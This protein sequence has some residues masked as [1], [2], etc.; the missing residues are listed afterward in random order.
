MP[1]TCGY[2]HLCHWEYVSDIPATPGSEIPGCRLAPTCLCFQDPYFFCS[3]PP[4]LTWPTWGGEDT[5]LLP[6]GTCQ[7]WDTGEHGE[8]GEW[9][10]VAPTP[11]FPDWVYPEL[12]VCPCSKPSPGLPRSGCCCGLGG[13]PASP[14]G[15][16]VRLFLCV[17]VFSALIPS[18]SL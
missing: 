13:E 8:Q 6:L 10:E 12:G 15:E 5:G 1:E 2:L 9:T 11:S 3:H 16:C 14:P 18:Y 4:S 7:I 17:I